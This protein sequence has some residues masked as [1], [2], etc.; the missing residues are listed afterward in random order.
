MKKF[1]CLIFYLVLIS[2]SSR[3][4][5]LKNTTELATTNCPA[6]GVCSL[7]VEENKTLNYINDTTSNLYPEITDGNNIVLTFEYKRN[8]IPNTADGHYVEQLIFELDP[9]NLE[10]SLSNNSLK[11]VKLLFARFCYCKGQTGYYKINN[12][13]LNIEKLADNKYY[14][15]ATFNQNNVPQIINSIGEVFELKKSP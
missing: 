12:G 14:I 6:D 1:V 2:C 9:N 10:I 11:N 7:K 3:E 15:T 13:T 5:V 4:Q 8:E